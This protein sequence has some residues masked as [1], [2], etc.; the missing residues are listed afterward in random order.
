MSGDRY[1]VIYSPK[2]MADLKSIYRYIAFRLKS[3]SAARN[4]VNRI[5]NMT[6]SLD[7]MPARFSCADS[8]PLKNLGIHKAPVDKYIVFYTI[9]EKDKKVNI[10]RVAYGGRDLKSI[11]DPE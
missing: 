2:S 3:P 4:Q 8:E 1:S 11:F 10:S 5:R 7:Y 9:D 6:R